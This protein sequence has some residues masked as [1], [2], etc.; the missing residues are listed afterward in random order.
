MINTEVNIAGIKMKNPVMTASGTFGYGREYG[1]YFDLNKL[2]AIVVKG[3]SIVPWKGNKPPRIVETSSGILNSIGLQNPGIDHLIEN[4]LPNL[5]KYD[6]PVIVNVVGKTIEEYIAVVE[7]LNDTTISGIELNISCPNVKEGGVAFG[8]RPDMASD[9]TS[10]IKKICKKP[11]IVK[12]SP[13]VTDITEIAKAVESA[14]ADA[15]S[16][17]NTLLGMAIDINSKRTI[18]ANNVGG[19]SGPAVKPVAVRMVWQ[20]ANAVKIPII[21][22]GGITSGEDAIEF[23]LAGASAVSV[24]AA[25]FVDPCAVPNVV[26][27]VEKY[28]IKYG[29][30]NIKEIVGQVKL[31]S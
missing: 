11:L 12:L 20:V 3:T 2:G 8:T 26:D 24:G 22:M 17:I 14:G 23:L 13:N 18:L 9:I 30:Q 19:L 29:H 4:E 5:L 27:G 31:N 7:K 25:N 15:V 16:L 28:L 1:E 6:L 21:G 10:K